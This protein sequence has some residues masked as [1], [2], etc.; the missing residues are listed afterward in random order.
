MLGAQARPLSRMAPRSAS[1]ATKAAAASGPSRAAIRAW[2]SWPGRSNTT[3]PSLSSRNATPGAA[4]ARRRTASSAWS[5]S[6]RGF[7]RNFRRA[8]VAK[9]RSLTTTRVP[10]APAAGAT[11]DT[12]PPS[13]EMVAA[14]SPRAASRGREVMAS[15]AAAP[16]EG[17]ASPRKPS[18]LISTRLSSVSLEVACRWTANAN[19][20]ADMPMPSSVTSMREMPPSRRATAI[21][22]AP[23]SSAFSTSS[24]TAAAGRSITSPAAMRLTVVSESSRMREAPPGGAVSN[25]GLNWRS[26][27]SCDGA[28]PS[29]PLRCRGPRE[30]PQIVSG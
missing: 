21:R 18:V 16:I 17:S 4:K 30:L 23:A 27:R 2:R 19:S 6:V 26:R 15:R 10:G 13:T 7:F 20:A 8:G 11:S 29:N 25:R 14:A 5:A 28:L 22:V 9:N 12:R 1:T 3:L 24:F